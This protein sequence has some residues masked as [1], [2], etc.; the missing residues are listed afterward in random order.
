MAG[1]VANLRAIELNSI[2]AE[3]HNGKGYIAYLKKNT[4]LH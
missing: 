1:A 2:E 3:V 4:R